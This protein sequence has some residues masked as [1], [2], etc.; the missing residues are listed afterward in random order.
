MQNDIQITCKS[1]VF[2]A[3]LHF[4]HLEDVRKFLVDTINIPEHSGVISFRGS[5]RY[6]DY[7]FNLGGLYIH[8]CETF[9]I[10]IGKTRERVH[11]YNRGDFNLLNK[12]IEVSVFI[13]YFYPEL[14]LNVDFTWYNPEIHPSYDREL[15]SWIEEE[16]YFL[17]LISLSE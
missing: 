4:L 12:L 5:V 7:H 17:R 10:L 13:H 15:F 11:I 2:D 3:T 9:T 1:E 16:Y 8:I 6:N 14:D